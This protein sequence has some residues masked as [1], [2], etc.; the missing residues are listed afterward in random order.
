MG[1]PK[2]TLNIFHLQWTSADANYMQGLTSLPSNYTDKQKCGER[3]LI[4]KGTR[5]GFLPTL[6]RAPTSSRTRIL[7]PAPRLH[8]TPLSIL[9]KSESADTE[10]EPVT[11]K[12]S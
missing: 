3:L 12:L 6:D 2:N 5:S 10:Q 1:L 8:P 4:P 7:R 11:A 9:T